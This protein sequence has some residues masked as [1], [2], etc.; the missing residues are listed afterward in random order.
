MEQYTKSE[1]TPLSLLLKNKI[2]ECRAVLSQRISLALSIVLSLVCGIFGLHYFS[3]SES[4]FMTKADIISSTRILSETETVTLYQMMK[5]VHQFFSENDLVYWADG[6]TLLGAVRHNG[7]IPWDDDIDLFF[8]VEQEKKLLSLQDV[9]LKKGY[10]LRSA[11]MVGYKVFS[12]ESELDSNG[13]G[14]PSMDLFLIRFDENRRTHF[15]DPKA[16]KKWGERDYFYKE[17]VYPLRLVPF[18]SL[19]IYAPKNP[20]RNLNRLYP[21]WNE[22]IKVHSPHDKKRKKKPILFKP[23]VAIGVHLMPTGPLK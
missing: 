22:V 7:I 23:E 9:L 14:Y 11:G 17:D 2:R 3:C 5:D 21:R 13:V 6:G 20:I 19:E 10:L 8:P 1:K 12:K 18:G 15:I 4:I 16:E